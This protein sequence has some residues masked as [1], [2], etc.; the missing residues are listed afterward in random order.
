MEEEDEFGDLYTDVLTSSSSNPPLLSSSLNP[1]S[2]SLLPHQN[3]EE[4]LYET[5]ISPKIRGSGTKNEATDEREP[6]T[7]E[8]PAP[9]V[10]PETDGWHD[11]RGGDA[12]C[13]TKGS[14][15][16]IDLMGSEQIPGLIPGL[17]AGPFKAEL[18]PSSET[19]VQQEKGE[20]EWDSDSE[21]DLK[22]VLNE[23][24][25]ILGPGPSAL[26]RR[27]DDGHGDNVDDDDEDDDDDGDDFVIVAGGDPHAQVVEDQDWVEDPSQIATDGDKPGAVDDRG[28]VAKV[29]AGV[30]ARVG[31]GGHGYHMHHSQF[32]YVR[33]GAATATGG[34][35]NNV[36]SVP[37]Q[38]RSLAPM[39]PMSGRGRGD[40][41]PMGGKIVPNMQKGFHAGYG[42]QTWANNSAMRGFNGME[43]TL[44]SHKTVFDIDIDAFEE[45]PWRQPG[46]DTSD[47]FNFGLDEDTWKE[48]CKQLEQLRLEATMQSKI[49]VYESGR[50]EQDY[51]PDLPPELAAA[52][53]LHD[54]SMD[55]QHI[56]KTDIGSSDAAGLVRGSTRVRP[57]IPTG[58]AIQVEGGYGERLPSIDTRPP[59]F[60]EPDSIIEIIP[61][62]T[63]E[64]DSVPSNDAAEQ[65]DNGHESEGLRNEGQEVEEDSKQVDADSIEQ[66]P[67]SYDGRKREMVPN[68]RGPILGPVHNT[69][70]EGDGILPFPPEAPL[71]YHPGSKVRAPIYPM[72]LLGAPHGGRGWSQGP[73]VHERYLP[74]NNEPPNVPILDESIRDHR[75]K[76][77]SF[78]SMEYKRS[79]E[80]PRPA[81]DE[82]A[83]E[84]SVDQRGD[85][86]DSEHMLPE[87]V[88]DEG[89]E[90]ISDMKMPN[91]AN[92]DIGSSVHPGKRQKLSSLIEPLP[93]LREPVDDL[94]ASRSDNSRGRSGSSKDYPKRHEVGE[95][96]EVEDGRV[97][98]LG[99]GKRRHGE[100]ESSFRRKDDYVRDGRHEADRKRVAMKGRED[101]Y[102]RAGN[103]AYPLREWALDVPH[104]IRKNEG[105]DRL[106]ERENGMG[107]WP[108]REEDTRGRREKDEDL[109]RRDRVEEMGSKHRG[110][111][112]EA[113]RSEKD[114]LNHLRKR[115]DDFDWRAHHDKEVSRQREGDDFSLVRHDALDDPRVKRRKDEE[116]QRRERDDKEDNIYRVREDASRRKREKDDSLDHRRREDRARSRDR[117][118]DH[119]SFRQRE[120]DSSWRQ[121]ERED[122]HRGESEGRSAQLSREREDARGS[123][124][125]DRTMEERAWVGGSR[126]IKDGSKSMG[127]DKD[128]H[129]KDKRRHSEQQPKIRDRIEEDTS[130]RRRGREESAY[131]R[132]S[133]PINEERNFRREKSTTQNESESQRMYKDRSKESN[134][135]KIKESERVD[136][137]DLASVA[138]NKHDRAVSHR[139]EKV[140]RR[141]VPYQA[142]SNAF[143]GRGE[144]RD[145]NHPRY[146]STSKKSSDHDSHVRQSAKPPKPSEEGVSD[147][148]S[149]R[150]GRSKLERWTSHKDREGNPQPKATRESES[151]EPEKIEALVFDQEDLEREDE[152]DVK[153]ENE[154]L[155][156]LGEEENSIGFEM[157]GTSNDDWLV[158]DADRNGEDRHLETVEKLKK[159]SERFK[160]PMPGEKESSRRVESE[161]ASQSEHVE[162]KQERPARKRRWV[163]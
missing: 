45:K 120:R 87:Q 29:N 123:A 46:V 116:V 69:V 15:D 20:E 53:G 5:L 8:K 108:W 30:V 163:S 149:S 57:Q 54:P 100:E 121:R 156:S 49:R 65:A 23:G 39:G 50:S 84:Q 146:S 153:R 154:K 133:H 119:H 97:R 159:R 83:R 150:R 17:S 93:S 61:Q 43:F 33:P 38:V 115:A 35:V 105:F 90:V 137:N 88:A 110:K 34:V 3:D 136:Q 158:V 114:E 11:D 138:S 25:D 95:E 130:T 44:P 75:K 99:E 73:T 6:E 62:G 58:R 37:G 47:F 40:W 131:S 72:G 9:Q 2:L 106:K 31:F 94:K 74:I 139:N 162:I 22:I 111:G 104:F 129:L 77:K 66:F 101:V 117:P 118:E 28:Q 143:T 135:R 80:V 78:D 126:A 59:R 70:R 67:Q 71:Q 145:R 124:R 140:A 1:I 113:S 85:A 151:S 24:H 21:D 102:R 144:P 64:D 107:S 63:P 60:R 56:N 125:S 92:E 152:Q 4:I 82:V 148:E 26:E 147:D 157:K 127:S 142:T 16:G 41:R 103:G 96:E 134:T 89:E 36:P 86:M 128:H 14:S 10:G 13:D 48:Y 160:L 42:L 122:H 55:N 132:E 68:R 32:K 27:D 18:F 19:R 91:E 7:L 51:D 98:Q 79:S 76:E 112:H 109:R 52:A 12:G 161:A 81:L 141:D 155:Q